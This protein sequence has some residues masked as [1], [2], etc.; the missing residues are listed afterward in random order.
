MII[1]GAAE[2]DLRPKGGRLGNRCAPGLHLHHS[3]AS[4]YTRHFI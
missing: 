1:D 2:V 3:T 4:P